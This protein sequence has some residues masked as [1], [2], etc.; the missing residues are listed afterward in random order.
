MSYEEIPGRGG[1]NIDPRDAWTGEKG[2]IQ[3]SVGTA[4]AGCGE[5]VTDGSPRN[6]QHEHMPLQSSCVAAAG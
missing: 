2:A 1:R 6:R 4:F 3:I 5:A